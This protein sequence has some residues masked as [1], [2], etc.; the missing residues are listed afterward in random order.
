MDKE[1]YCIVCGTRIPFDAQICPLCGSKQPDTVEN[2]Q[3]ITSPNA[4]PEEKHEPDHAPVSP[5][6]PAQPEEPE[7]NFLSGFSRKTVAIAAAAAVLI[8]VILCLV[9][10]MTVSNKAQRYKDART[11]H[12]K[13]D[14]GLVTYVQAYVRQNENTRL[15]G[16]I[17]GSDLLETLIMTFYPDNRVHVQRRTLGIPTID[18]EFYYDLIDDKLYTW[19]DYERINLYS[20]FNFRIHQNCVTLNSL[21]MQMDSGFCQMGKADYTR[22]DIEQIMRSSGGVV[23][24]LFENI[25]PIPLTASGYSYYYDDSDSYYDDSDD[26]SSDDSDDY[27]YDDSDWDEYTWIGYVSDEEGPVYLYDDPDLYEDSII[28]VIPDGEAVVVYEYFDGK[29][30]VQYRD[31]YGY[32]NETN[33]IMEGN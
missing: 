16:N 31:N 14:E 22:S 32:I 2:S 15:S 33:Q 23:D 8:V 25:K 20:I 24:K 29:Y 9:S 12:L 18:R 13:L 3:R 5:E 7:E 19:Y 6:Q 27:Y 10:G 11:S 30:Y 1:K 4:E 28:C 17:T 21:N 26:Y